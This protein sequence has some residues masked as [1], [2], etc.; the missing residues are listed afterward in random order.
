MKN[1]LGNS[2]YKWFPAASQNG[3]QNYR[4]LICFYLKKQRKSQCEVLSWKWIWFRQNHSIFQDLHSVVQVQMQND[5]RIEWMWL[6]Y[7]HV[8]YFS[9]MLKL[10]ILLFES[11]T[12]SLWDHSAKQKR[13]R[14]KGA[15]W[16]YQI[17]LIS[18][19]R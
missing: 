6:W 11:G 13:I 1:A 4:R 9:Y 10:Y 5:E 2:K 12:D 16:W 14:L 17:V 18:C 8:I 7:D 15:S 3:H 19:E